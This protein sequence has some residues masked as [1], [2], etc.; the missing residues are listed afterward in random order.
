MSSSTSSSNWN[1][2]LQERESALQREKAFQEQVF[3]V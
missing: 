3:I 1:S 2:A